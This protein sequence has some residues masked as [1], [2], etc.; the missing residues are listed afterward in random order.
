MT[1][2]KAVHYT[3]YTWQLN[4]KETPYL[5]WGQNLGSTGLFSEK[6]QFSGR[7]EHSTEFT[8]HFDKKSCAYSYTGNPIGFLKKDIFDGLLSITTFINTVIKQND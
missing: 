7:T 2:L 1:F 8:V 4:L 3:F 5:L 6:S